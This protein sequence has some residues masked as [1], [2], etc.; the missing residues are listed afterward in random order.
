MPDSIDWGNLYDENIVREMREPFPEPRPCWIADL[1]DPIRG[2]FVP[3][4]ATALGK[5]YPTVGFVI[6]HESGDP[7]MAMDIF[8]DEAAAQK[9]CDE[10]NLHLDD[11]EE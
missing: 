7:D 8:D 4:R 11:D 3:L 6:R 2:R 1:T 9:W 10:A 5:L